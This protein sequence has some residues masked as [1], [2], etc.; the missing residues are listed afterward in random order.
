MAFGD[1]VTHRGHIPRWR[2]RECLP[3]ICD[4]REMKYFPQTNRQCDWK[5]DKYLWWGA[6]ANTSINLWH[7]A[8][9]AQDSSRLNIRGQIVHITDFGHGTVMQK[10]NRNATTL[11]FPPELLLWWDKMWCLFLMYKIL[12]VN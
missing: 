12:E 7:R 2:I 3:V 9:D 8:S 6:T 10:R 11:L 4:R 1:C 5:V